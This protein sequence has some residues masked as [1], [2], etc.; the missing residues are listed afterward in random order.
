MRVQTIQNPAT[1]LGFDKFDEND[2]IF[3]ALNSSDGGSG[4]FFSAREGIFGPFPSRLAALEALNRFVIEKS[5]LKNY[6][7]T[8]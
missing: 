4:W 3:P 2:R 8:Q 1:Y 6:R 5:A 7:A